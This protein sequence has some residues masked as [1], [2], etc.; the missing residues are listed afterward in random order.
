MRPSG[1]NLSRA[2]SRAGFVG[3]IAALCAVVSAAPEAAAEGNLARRAERL[4]ELKIDA[5]KGFSKTA[6]QLETGKYY[7]WRVVSDGRDEYSFRFPEL[8]RN[9]WFDQIVIEDK[10]VKPFGGVYS[11]EFD[12]E[13][14]IDVFFVPIRPG[15]YEFFVENYRESGMLGAIEVR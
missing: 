10:E 3:L 15:T 14:E 6:Y 7:R 1:L 5:A 13:G 4:E 12:D 8:A 9:A 2:G 11:L